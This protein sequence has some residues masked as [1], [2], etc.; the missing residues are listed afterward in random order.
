MTTWVSLQNNH[1]IERWLGRQV[2]RKIRRHKIKNQNEL[3]DM[4]GKAYK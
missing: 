2:D 3:K 4:Q 1:E